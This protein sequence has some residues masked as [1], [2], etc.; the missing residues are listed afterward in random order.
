MTDREPFATGRCTCGEVV[1]RLEDRP[2]FVHCCHCTWCQRQ[3]GSAF[4]LNAIIEASRVTLVEG[5]VDSHMLPTPSGRGQKLSRCPGCRV[6]LWSNYMGLGEAVNFVRVGTL[7]D[8]SLVPPDIH[9][10]TDTKAP[11]V[12]LPEDL[13]AMTGFYDRREHWPAD[14]LDRLKALRG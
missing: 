9:I 6:V 8:P 11:W 5:K 10:F 13:P 2:M 14:S 12:T 3:T 1:Y 4:A 7:D